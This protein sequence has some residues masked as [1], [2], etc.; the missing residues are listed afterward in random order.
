MVW[1][2]LYKYLKQAKYLTIA[3]FMLLGFESVLAR[4]QNYLIA[5]MVGALSE[6]DKNTIVPILIKYL[7]FFVFT[8]LFLSLLEAM[9]RFFEAKFLPFIYTRT[10]KDLFSKVHKHAM[11]FFEE[12]MSGNISGKVSNVLT[13]IQ[14]MYGNILFG[15]FVPLM[16][17]ATSLFFIALADKKLSLIIGCLNMLFIRLQTVFL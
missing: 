12:E 10:A 13:Q 3:L 16:E 9:R 14:N 15:C 5:N 8:L 6:F 4:F 2:F 11:R 7:I 17:M 1:Q